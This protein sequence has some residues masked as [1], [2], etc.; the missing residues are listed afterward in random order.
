MG[1]EGSDAN[2]FLEGKKGLILGIANEHSIAY[3][4]GEIFH[5]LGAELAVTYLNEKVERFVK[6][7]C[8]GV[9]M[10]DLYAMR[11]RNAGP[12]GGSL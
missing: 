6:P 12:V 11:R 5:A 4:C 10:P 3:G 7:P 1:K 8:R 9:G 2:R